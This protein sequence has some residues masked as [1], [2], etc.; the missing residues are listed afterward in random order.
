MSNSGFRW[1]HFELE[2][3]ARD[4]GLRYLIANAM[5]RTKRLILALIEG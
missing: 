1:N 3:I 4:I 2:V 5:S